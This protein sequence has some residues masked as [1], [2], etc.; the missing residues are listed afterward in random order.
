MHGK[1]FILCTMDDLFLKVFNDAFDRKKMPCA[2]EMNS[3]WE[4][5]YVKDKWELMRLALVFMSY[6]KTGAKYRLGKK[7]LTL[8][9]IGTRSHPYGLSALYYILNRDP[10][11]FYMNMYQM[12]MLFGGWKSLIEIW[13]YDIFRHGFR[14]D[15]CILNYSRVAKFMW[16]L[17]DD[18]LC[19]PDIVKAFPIIRRLSKA[20]TPHKK[21]RNIIG[22]YIRSM[23]CPKGDE[24]KHTRNKSYGFIRG[25]YKHK[26]VRYVKM[27]MSWARS[28]PRED[29][30]D[31]LVNQKSFKVLRIK[32]ET[33]E[34]KLHKQQKTKDHGKG[35]TY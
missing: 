28:M 11:M 13:E 20:R 30:Y 35:R 4:E 12:G 1:P 19:G 9:V 7:V 14:L 32:N 10:S 34:P 21:A 23:V 29:L 33:M 18:L 6:S 24:H 31:R 2:E 3:T 27:D 16:R 26:R 17:K 8:D 5:L 15:E 25:M 22:K